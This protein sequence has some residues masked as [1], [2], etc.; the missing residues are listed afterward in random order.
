MNF[1]YKLS[2]GPEIPLVPRAELD[3]ELAERC[4]RTPVETEVWAINFLRE[5]LASN[6]T[7]QRVLELAIRSTHAPTELQEFLFRVLCRHFV[8]AN[9]SVIEAFREVYAGSELIAVHVS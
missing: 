4:D 1:V 7:D 8:D 5:Y 9:Q 6:C 2:Y 3:S